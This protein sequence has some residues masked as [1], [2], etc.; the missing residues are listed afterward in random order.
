[1]DV[2]LRTYQTRTFFSGAPFAPAYSILDFLGMVETITP[3]QTA[4]NAEMR[5]SLTDLL[6]PSVLGNWARPGK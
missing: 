6:T 3:R 1:M 5:G 2:L 4:I